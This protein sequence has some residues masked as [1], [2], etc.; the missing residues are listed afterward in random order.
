[1]PALAAAAR[2]APE[3]LVGAWYFSGWFNCSTPGCY[4]HFNGFAPRGE[5][6]PDFFPYYPERTPLLGLLDD[7][8]ATIAAEVHAADAAGLD[9]FHVLFYD[10]DGERDCGPN[11]DP[12]LSPCL[13]VSLAFMLNTSSVWAN[14]TGRLRF[15]LAYSNDVDASRAGMFVGAAGLAAWQS[16]VGTWVRAMQH[17]RYLAVGGRPLFQV[18][19]PDI[20]LLQCGG[21]VSR[22][23]ELLELLR[24]AGRAAGVGAPVIGGGW[25]NPSQPP[26]AANAPLP[27]PEGYM[28]Y[29]S[30]D[31][32]CNAGP[33]D[34]ARVP[35]AAP[36][37]CMATCNTTG[38]CTSFAFY[39][40][41]G[42]CVLKSYAGP[43]AGGLGDFY[44]RVLDDIAWEWRGTYNDAEPICYNGPGQTNP[45][46][47]PEYE[48]AWW[49]NATANGAKIFPYAEVLRYQAQ[50]RGNQS[51]DKVPY[52]PN[53]IAGFDPRPWEEQGPSFTD[54]TQ[55]EWTAALSQA[56]DLVT[57]PANRAF[58][59]PDA[60]SP[61]GVQP[62][63]SIYAWNELGEGGFLMPTQLAGF[64]KLEVLSEVF[65]RGRGR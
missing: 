12:N 9:F 35:G 53:V 61:T 41:N 54:P 36:E 19:I 16:R 50:A 25:L 22:A 42:T 33:C 24:A 64:M 31:V 58:G 32:P 17:P 5:R 65:G 14:T 49:P 3:P 37:D 40:A 2:A 4:S 63:L 39:A 48:N 62:A 6:V 27:H 44:V 20:F 23:E 46:R 8:P 60:T 18:L 57:D 13:D 52:L 47:C 55:A 26:G 38:G 59:I 30:T 10:S 56:R 43:G 1:L 29:K 45:G 28:L 15:A 11:P 21:N 51:A 34:I 7:A